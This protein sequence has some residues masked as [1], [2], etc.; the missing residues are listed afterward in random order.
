L[1]GS[2]SGKRITNH[3]EDANRKSRWRMIP[4]T[5]GSRLPARIPDGNFPYCIKRQTI[6]KKLTNIKKSFRRDL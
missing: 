4:R 6:G 3:H 5:G 1:T 2:R